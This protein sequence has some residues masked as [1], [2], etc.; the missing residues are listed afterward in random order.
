MDVMKLGSLN[1]EAVQHTHLEVTNAVCD[2]TIRDLPRG[3]HPNT[4][5]QSRRRGQEGLGQSFFDQQSQIDKPHGCADDPGTIM[6]LSQ[7]KPG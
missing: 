2:V 6:V 4:L 5:A 1:I 7:T 3:G